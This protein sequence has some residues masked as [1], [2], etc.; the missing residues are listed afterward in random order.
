MTITGGA[1]FILRLPPLS[2]IQEVID[3]T[4]LSVRRFSACFLGLV[5]AA[6]TVAGCSGPTQKITLHGTVTYKGERLH[7]GMVKFAGPGDAVTAA[8]IQ[9]DGTFT[10][11]DVAPGEVKV[12]VVDTPQGSRSSAPDKE[13]TPPVTLPAKYRDPEKSELKYT[14]TSNTKELEIKLD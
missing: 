14:I 9:S 7:S 4:T 5:A 6:V 8:Q 13:K 2:L 12:A 3:M 11:T 1:H 10:I